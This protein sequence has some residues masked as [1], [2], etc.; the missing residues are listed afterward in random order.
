LG[1][2]VGVKNLGIWS[3]LASLELMRLL[4]Q[5]PFK[6]FRLAVMTMIVGAV[7]LGYYWSDQ[8]S[9]LTWKD[10]EELAPWMMFAVSVGMYLAIYFCFPL[11]LS[12]ALLERGAESP[13][14]LLRLSELSG[15]ELLLVKL[16]AG[17]GAFIIAC[18]PIAPL[19]GFA[20]AFSPPSLLAFFIIEVFLFWVMIHVGLIV[21]AFSVS[22]TRA[23]DA[24]RRSIFAFVMLWFIPFA[25]PGGCQYFIHTFPDVPWW[26]FLTI[27]VWFSLFLPWL[28]FKRAGEQLDY[29]DDLVGMKVTPPEEVQA[30]APIEWAQWIF[31]R[32]LLLIFLG[33]IIPFMSFYGYFLQDRLW[34]A[35]LARWLFFQIPATIYLVVMLTVRLTFSNYFEPT[36][37]MYLMLLAA[38]TSPAWWFAKLLF[39]KS[40]TIIYALAFFFTASLLMFGV[41]PAIGVPL[42][43]VVV[44][45]VLLTTLWV[46]ALT[47]VCRPR[48]M[49][50]PA[51]IF[52]LFLAYLLPWM[53]PPERGHFGNIVFGIA[54]VT[55]IVTLYWPYPA[56]IVVQAAAYYHC[57]F[58]A[59]PLL[60]SA[61]D[62]NAGILDILGGIV[63]ILDI[64]LGGGFRFFGAGP[65]RVD[66]AQP[67]FD[68]DSV[69]RTFVGDAIVLLIAAIWLR[70]AFDVMVGRSSFQPFRRFFSR[71]PKHG[72]A[73]AR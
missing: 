31:G 15:R 62:A 48:F 5:Q 16:A 8:E 55:T 34:D 54:F 73:V 20:F 52:Y 2:R 43:G 36:G 47:V 9:S 45:E 26:V 70:F 29:P 49:A 68:A 63:M 69:Q 6:L 42:W 1:R 12:T 21:L 32:F 51:I 35:Y 19:L 13:T 41:D 38:P 71:R 11:I 56:V 66:V 44:V 67:L 50:L 7:A 33:G 59:F 39:F 64:F 17:I 37:A 25:A 46:F 72:H 65:G 24:Y 30:S 61:P 28:A 53:L 10:L 60:G 23:A 57:R 14:M 27:N 3:T 40:R 58:L 22:S 4:R 18:L